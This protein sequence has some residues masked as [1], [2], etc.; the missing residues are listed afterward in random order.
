MHPPFAGI[1]FDRGLLFDTADLDEA[2]DR[3]ARVFNPHRLQVLGA[4]R[5]LHSR[6][7][8][9]PLGPLSLNRLTWG[10]PVAV[11]PDRLERYYLLSIATRGHALFDLGG[12]PTPVSA[13]CAGLV[14]SAPRFRFT[15]SDDF[16]QVVVRVERNAVDDA[17]LALAGRPAEAPIDFDCALPLDGPAWRAAEPAL[18]MLAAGVRGDF[19]GAGLA[20]L[21]ARVQDLL[22]TTLLLRQ[23]HSL[24]AALVPAER[25]LPLHLRRAEA[26][27]RERLD[28]PL[29][30]A[31]VARAGGVAMR[32]LQAAFQH[33]HGLGPMQWLRRERLQ[34]VRAALL[35][36]PAPRPSVTQAARRFGFTHLGEFARAYRRAFG[37]A[38]SQTL[39]R[40]G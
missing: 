17:W 10:A 12:R 30:L 2:R 37:E 13:R 24:R 9:L 20:H 32:T 35:A 28:Q 8:H 27:M 23:P 7:E 18:E 29:T 1:D 34:A 21:A 25:A 38:P 22:L 3:C 11:D 6:M 19:A 14:S 4:A 40:R 15:A 5:R 31:Q 16:E 26:W 39:A 36:D 33:Q